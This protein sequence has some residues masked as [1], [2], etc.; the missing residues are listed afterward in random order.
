M[1]R[2]TQRQLLSS[3]I[4]VL[5][6]VLVTFALAVRFLVVRGWR[7]ESLVQLTALAEGA[8][9]SPDEQDFQQTTTPTR[10]MLLTTVKHSSGG[11]LMAN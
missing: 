11:Q 6:A 3:Y 4:L 9:A 8:A 10:K 5:V 7:D 1:F 2:R